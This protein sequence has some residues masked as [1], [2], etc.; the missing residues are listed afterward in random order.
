MITML[1]VPAYTVREAAKYLGVSRDHIYKMLRDGRLQGEL[2][3]CQ[4][5][6]IPYDE[7][8]YQVRK[9]DEERGYGRN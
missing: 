2:D 3:V 8:L 1:P 5:L 6:R 7:L 9:M 4:Q